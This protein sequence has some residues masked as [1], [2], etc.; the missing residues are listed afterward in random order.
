[1]CELRERARGNLE[2]VPCDD[3][4]QASGSWTC[5]SISPRQVSLTGHCVNRWEALQLSVA[6]LSEKVCPVR[7]I[8]PPSQHAPEKHEQ[9]AAGALRGPHRPP[10]RVP[11]RTERAL[12][13]KLTFRFLL[14]RLSEKET[15]VDLSSSSVWDKMPVLL[16]S[17][18]FAQRSWSLL[19][20]LWVDS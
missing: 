10:F 12:L 2:W 3:L 15:A 1:M 18:R 4:T 5:S 14:T 7:R 16:D 20:Q 6:Q 11:G 17:T 8:G 19:S 9:A 13:S